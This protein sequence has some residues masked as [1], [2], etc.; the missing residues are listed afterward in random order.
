[1]TEQKRNRWFVTGVMGVS[2]L[3]F[4]G[5]SVLPLIGSLLKPPAAQTGPNA[6]PSP[7]AQGSPSAAVRAKLETEA[8]GYELVLQR[9]PNNELSLIHISEPTR[10]Y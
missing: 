5:L 7:N 10:P 4:L 1:M 9:E 8:K 2:V 3:A 6:S